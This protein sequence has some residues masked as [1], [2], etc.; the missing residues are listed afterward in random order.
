MSDDEI[1]Y[2]VISRSTELTG[3]TITSARNNHIVI[4]SPSGPNEALTTGEAFVAGIA[5]CGVTLV[6]S[7]ARERGIAVGPL[8]CDIAAVRLKSSPADISRLEVRFDFQHLDRRQAT[9]L[10]EGWRSR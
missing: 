8:S 7:I 1:R 9:E 6:Q 5:A 2:G 10:V 3:R 4:D